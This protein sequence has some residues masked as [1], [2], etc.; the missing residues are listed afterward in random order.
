MAS[1][2]GP[3][4]TAR[5]G[6]SESRLE[7]FKTVLADNDD[8]L[9]HLKQA[10]SAD[11]S[12]VLD[13][14]PDSHKQNLKLANFV[15]EATDDD[16]PLAKAVLS[17]SN[18]TSTRQIALDYG[19]GRVKTIVRNANP[20]DGIA[21]AAIRSP[22]TVHAKRTS[23][24][25]RSPGL[26]PDTLKALKFR[27]RLFEVEPTAVLQQ[28]IASGDEDQNPSENLLGHTDDQINQQIVKFLDE[29]PD[30]NIRTQSVM[31][32]IAADQKAP[33]TGSA[34]QISPKTH[35]KVVERL[36]L[37]QRVQAL[38]PAPE[39]IKPL[40]L[41][42]LTSAM[43]VS[44]VPKDQFVKL[45]APKIASSAGVDNTEANLLAS[46][47]HDHAVLSRARTD[48]AL[49]QLHQALK[50][51]GLSAIDG[52][53]SLEERKKQ[54][55][56]LADKVMGTKDIVNLDDLFQDMDFCECDSCQDV[57]S[58]TAYY[59]DLLQYLRNNNLD[60]RTDWPN[61]GEEGYKDTVLEKLFIRR[62]DLAHL[63]LTCENANT[64]LPYI[65]L[66]NEVMESFVIHL[67]QYAKGWTP[68]KQ[69]E[70]ETWNI[71]GEDT[72]ELLASPSHTRKPAYC[73]LKEATYPIASLP[74]FQP[75]DAIRLYLQ[76]LGV[77]RYEL[78]DVFRLAKRQ[79]KVPAS[80][81]T[82]STKP[83]FEALRA[84]LQDRATAAEYLGLSPD[85]YIII[86]RES[87]WPIGSSVLTDTGTLLTPEQYR[88]DIG[89]KAS[90][91]YW[92][93]E[94]DEKLLSEATTPKTGLSWVKAQFLG[95]SG[96]SYAETADLVRTYYVNSMYPS[97]KD[98]VLLESI[99][100]SYRFLQHLASV[101]PDKSTKIAALT[102]F[103]IL[104]QPWVHLAQVLQ[105]PPTGNLLI[106][107][108][109][110]PCFT[111]KEIRAWV[112]RWFE[113]IGKLVVLEAGEGPRLPVKGYIFRQPP[114]PQ[115][116]EASVSFD[117]IN[118]AVATFSS[119]SVTPGRPPASHEPEIL[120][121][122]NEG[123][124][125]LD[126]DDKL[127]G[128]VAMDGLVLYKDW[129]PIRTHYPGDHIRVIDMPKQA[130]PSQPQNDD[131]ENDDEKGDLPLSRH[132]EV[133]V[134]NLES[135]LEIDTMFSDQNAIQVQWE[136]PPDT[137]SIEN[138]R[139]LHLN[140]TPLELEEW[141]RIN[142]FIRLYRKLQP[143]SWTI[144]QVDSCLRGLWKVPEL[145]P[146]DTPNTSSTEEE[147][148][149][150]SFSKYQ[151]K[152]CRCPSADECDCC[153]DDGSDCDDSGPSLCHPSNFIN[154]GP[155]FLKELKSVKELASIT[156]L[157]DR[158][159]CL[160]TDI[161]SFGEQSLYSRLFV[162]HD[163]KS[164]DPVFHSDDNG[165]YLTSEPKIGDHVPVLQ[166][167]LQIKP[168]LFDVAL[169]RAGLT[170]NDIIT[171]PNLSKLYRLILFSKILGMSQQVF[172]ESLDIFT[173]PFASASRS[174]EIYQLWNR[175]SAFGLNVKQLRYV[176]LNMEDPL[177][178]VGPS[179]VTILKS[180]KVILDGLKAIE[181]ANP[182]LNE[183][184]ESNLTANDVKT[185]A[186]LVFEPAVVDAITGL[187]EGT[188]LY[189]TNAPVGLVLDRAKLSNK[190]IYNDPLTPGNRKATVSIKGV[191]TD[192]EETTAIA[193]AQGSENWKAAL[194]RLRKQAVNRV[195]STLPPMFN[196]KIEEAAA[197]LTKGDVPATPPAS[198]T[199][200]GDPGSAPEKRK[201]FLR[202]FM[203]FLR[204]QLAS[205][206][207]T[208]TISGVASTSP[209]ITSLLLT[210]II[211]TGPPGSSTYAMDILKGLAKH[212]STPPPGTWT[213]FLLPGSTDSFSFYG[214][215]DSEPPPLLLDGK[216]IPFTSRNEDP[217]NIWWTDPVLLTGGK[218]YALVVSGQTVPGDLQWKTARS[219]VVA[220]PSLS[221]IPDASV[222]DTS[223]VFIRM[224][225]ASMIIQAFSL[226]VT[227][228]EYLQDHGSDF[229]GLDFNGMSFDAAKRLLAYAELRDSI[230]KREKTLIDLFLWASQATSTTA[231]ALSALISSVTV[232]DKDQVAILLQAKNFDLVNPALF[233]NEIPLVKLSKAIA[234]I[235]KIAIPNL[236]LL[237]SW[238]DLKLDFNK[239]WSNAKT[240][241]HFIR[242]KYSLSDFEQAIKPSHDQLRKNQRDALIAYLLVQPCLQQWGVQD[243]DALFEFFL[244]DVQMGSCMQTSRIKQAISS[245]QQFVQRCM[246]GLEENPDPKI[247]VPNDALNAKRWEW[248]NKQ[249]VWTANRKVFLYPENWIVPSLRDDKTPVYTAME[250]EMLQK[251]LN[252][253]NIMTS[254]KEFV[255]DLDQISH[256]RAVGLYVEETGPTTHILHCI[257]MTP[258]SPALFFYRTFESSVHE[259]KPWNQIPI[260]IP[261]YSQKYE[262]AWYMGGGGEFPQYT[263]TTETLSGCYTVPFVWNSRILLF[264][265]EINPKAVP[266]QT[267]LDQEFGSMTKGDSK[268]K[269]KE[270]APQQCWEVKLAYTEYRSG[271]WSQKQI[272]ESSIL[273]AAVTDLTPT[274]LF[275]FIPQ[276]LRSSD[277]G[278]WI[279]IEV[280]QCVQDPN[281]HNS[282][283]WPT[284]EGSRIGQFLFSGST[285]TKGNSAT[286]DKPQNW[287]T[288]NFHLIA[289]RS[290]GP[291][292]NSLQMDADGKLPYF[293]TPPNISYSRSSETTGALDKMGVVFY[294]STNT[295]F[296]FHPFTSRLLGAASK[297]IDK[298]DPILDVLNKPGSLDVTIAEAAFGAGPGETGADGK[299]YPSYSELSR[300]YSNYNWELGFHAPM[301]IA[302]NLLTSQQF[303]SALE[304]MHHVFNPYEDGPDLRRV[305]KWAP[306]KNADS[307]RVLETILDR[308]K[309]HEFDKKITQ[310]RDSPFRP[311]VVARGR[312]VA[313][314]KWTVMTYIKTLIAYG[315]FYFRRRTL[316]DLPRA[317]QLYV[318]ASHMY[319]PKGEK[320][321]KRGKKIPQTY[322]SLLNKWDAFSNA[323]VQ[324]ELLFPFSN[325]TPFPWGVTQDTVGSAT[326]PDVK[327]VALANIFGFAT[328]SYFCL[329]TN[330][331]LQNLRTI[332][333]TR[334]FNIRNC[335]DIDG[336]P[337]PLALWE[338]P[339]DPGLLVQA[340]ASGLSLSSALND[341]NVS[342]PN[343]RFTWLLSKALEICSELKSLEASFLSIKEKRDGEALQILRTKHE[344]TI[345]QKTLEMKKVQLE[346]AIATVTTLVASQSSPRY[347][348][349]FFSSLTG[350]EVQPLGGSQPF[351]QFD[352]KIDS[353][354]TDGDLHLNSTEKQ[355][356]DEAREAQQLNK[357]ASQLEIIAGILHAIPSFNIHTTPWGC[358]VEIAWGMTNIAA[359]LGA[360]A[361]WLQV[362]AGDH[363]FKSSEAARKSSNIRQYQDR[364]HQ[365]NI[366]GFEFEHI[367]TQIE[368][369]K[370]RIKL[371]NLDIENQQKIIDNSKE[372][373]DFLHNKY[374]NDELYQYLESSTRQ[375]M[376]QTYQLAYDLAKKAELAYRFERK[377]TDQPNFISFGYFDPGRDGLQSGQ[378]LYLALKH[379]E[380]AYQA[381][382]G[383][384]YEITKAIS[385]RQLNPYALLRLRETGSCQ[386]DV[387]EV[388]FDMDFPGHYFRRLKTVS[389]S[390]PCVVGPY[391]GVNATLRLMS[392]K[393]R[394]NALSSGSGKDYIEKMEG[395]LD[396]RFRT[397]HVP[398]D[399]IAVSTG[400]ND[401]GVFELAIKDERYLPFEGAGAVGSWSLQL[402]SFAQFDYN[403]I[404]DVVLTMRYTSCDGGM[405]LRK[406]AAENVASYMVTIEGYS[407]SQG[408]LT[409]FDLRSEFSGEWAKLAAAAGAGEQQ[410]SS[411]DPVEDTLVLRDLNMRL[412]AFTGGRTVHA[413]DVAILTT[414][415]LQSS[416]LALDFAYK[417]P[418]GPSDGGN[419]VTFD[420][421]PV[422]IGAQLNMYRL[423]EADNAVGT[424]GL[425]VTLPSDAKIDSKTRMWMIVRYKMTKG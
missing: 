33:E 243:A 47:I 300:P 250:G 59:V 331:D 321:P 344:I 398:I 204:S 44:S 152:C 99:R 284:N 407:D 258:G 286:G 354:T 391:V 229:A 140:G 315:D 415:S 184:Q 288:T 290:H 76:Y 127:I 80:L 88:A 303:D 55:S 263:Y 95:R 361:R 150:F 68:S 369:Q 91:V 421:G 109:H 256:L 227:E 216:N 305:W 408:L 239:T 54:F 4:Q 143:D 328:S 104:S 291:N 416:N 255:T 208:T 340:V 342:L 253:A 40:I 78:I 320:I 176:V 349:T 266:N 384:D 273:T 116:A 217:N 178:P 173:D 209:E 389:L 360:K 129:K 319:G 22:D 191:L 134:I 10:E 185:K 355:E 240:V 278:E 276:S 96:L 228:V 327:E 103:L 89:V 132:R 401:S 142:R 334:M 138:T 233:K 390:I 136:I 382:R 352:I 413:T 283:E 162:T 231:E 147:E 312:I 128:L 163:L 73:I 195:K 124:E 330:P 13:T 31:S 309:P 94:T 74:Y 75:L 111:R 222:A 337:M 66:S 32:V 323:A 403:S 378:Q 158:L 201:Y 289:G 235:S 306:F 260:D 56:E 383:Y 318:L 34:L 53:L 85:E 244:L 145:P 387:P 275:Q 314:M 302:T 307:I 274:D 223:E 368:A 205:Q 177:Q 131:E 101:F 359:A 220:I 180:T 374:T 417:P 37:L 269:A 299:S 159:L 409:L 26:P 97:G 172:F 46:S 7:I 218:L 325:Q 120:G 298:I 199:D 422:K 110:P 113:C 60:T 167:A 57:T 282:G 261:T 156:G 6:L 190:I 14:A 393:Y 214:S 380:S 264:I 351:K 362:E 61:I 165:N 52:T 339:I 92:G 3:T 420:S 308:L 404:A 42:G 338:P 16:V 346:E 341:L 336:K 271:R 130:K 329:P 38:A 154:I 48:S 375:N 425:K 25:L 252:P 279:S 100:F 232:W 84:Q 247:N 196:D 135:H 287:Q 77:S 356:M 20:T 230:P 272:S 310:W 267:A 122:L 189:K 39:A 119:R 106:P 153:S 364:I 35:P 237:L 79:W 30:F 188:A 90:E 161:D 146:P 381:E 234:F 148:E 70:L 406:A 118:K 41:S 394:W 171:I 371:Q 367:N 213:G 139:L 93:Y 58:P 295:D 294:D 317:L 157:Q 242:S 357:S 182:D 395:K 83:L 238:S 224:S 402:P 126:S 257:G 304:M 112:A 8:L 366:A 27:R 15:A 174:L 114:K 170:R 107:P 62:P 372:V 353:P 105:Q 51:S 423:N 419:E 23:G 117:A 115:R 202:A 203:G 347:R 186:T 192:D 254:F 410:P 363:Q 245:V 350:A 49:L 193:L 45:L 50:G 411:G 215:S 335:L 296:F 206:L 249:T 373:E 207:I 168:K 28:M 262:L 19:F 72:N 64:V 108:K 82:A 86:A 379:M 212:L 311:H 98:K 187:I 388:L 221:L 18:A 241:L 24:S 345:A 137:C 386:I 71:E 358:G 179:K 194:G 164:V 301:Q 169:Q 151:H 392:H 211:K 166:A 125:I 9:S 133:V 365:M 248:M 69:V 12:R 259:W 313:Y 29:R 219:G 376:Y 67:E 1:S 405:M 141:D 197:V 412:P 21:T 281:Q 285:I 226:A 316:E 2:Q 414:L 348:H 198:G 149:P 63:K 370:V 396:D 399:A 385:L 280:W 270:L 11:I 65:D 297:S 123:G 277:S 251:D 43:R 333:D 121:Y 332:I 377:A 324:L 265:G 155:G 322:F 181:T 87:I 293:N 144:Q 17:D 5:G 326:I 36:K 102:E 210:K 292:L 200:L 400:Q 246:L 236:E 424:W 183:T 225:K 418:T 160:W 397:D 343:Y 268:V 175:I 81:L